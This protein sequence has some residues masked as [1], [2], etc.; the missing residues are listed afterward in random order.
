MVVFRTNFYGFLQFLQLTVYLAP[1]FLKSADKR[2][3]NG[4]IIYYI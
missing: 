2:Q 3:N 4:Y 1:L